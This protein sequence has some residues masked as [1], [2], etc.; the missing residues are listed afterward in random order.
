MITDAIFWI[1]KVQ[2]T[3]V[4]P[5]YTPGHAPLSLRPKP[6][7]PGQPVPT[8]TVRPPMAIHEPRT[9]TVTATQIQYTQTVLLNFAGLTW[10][11]I[12]VAT[13]VPASHVQAPPSVW[14]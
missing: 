13:L 1:E 6:A 3:L 14:H 4:V 11:H 7:V 2:Y 10:P 5:P 9:I 8:F 12:S